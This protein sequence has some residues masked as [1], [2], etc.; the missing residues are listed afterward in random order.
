MLLAGVRAGACGDEL[1]K[2]EAG[3]GT[4]SVDRGKEPS[5]EFEAGTSTT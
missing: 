1:N 4:S 5:G 3:T 2:P